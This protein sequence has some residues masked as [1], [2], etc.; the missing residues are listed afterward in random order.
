MHL[1]KSLLTFTFLTYTTLALPA[2]SFDTITLESRADDPF[3]K[4]TANLKVLRE[5]FDKANAKICMSP[6]YHSSS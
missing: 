2:V 1:L 6:S 4:T 3:A 5:S